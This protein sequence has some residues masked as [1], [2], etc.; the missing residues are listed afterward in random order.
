MVDNNKQTSRL[1][2]LRV[3]LAV[4]IISTAVRCFDEVKVNIRQRCRHEGAEI[5]HVHYI[6]PLVDRTR[7]TVLTKCDLSAPYSTYF[8]QASTSTSAS[9]VAHPYFVIPLSVFILHLS[10]ISVAVSA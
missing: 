5:Y 8:M 2:Y 1:T 10:S 4:R 6:Q 9:F 3:C 7:D